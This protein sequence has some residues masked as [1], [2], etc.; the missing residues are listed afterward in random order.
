M[1]LFWDSSAILAIVFSEKRSFLATEAWDTA[2]FDY[3][4]RWLK[5]EASSALARRGATPAQWAYF[6]DLMNSFRFLDLSYK[7][8]NDVCTTNR[9][10]RLR[11][12]DAGH[13]FCFR[14]ASFVLPHLQFV[15]FDGEMVAIARKQG[16]RLWRP[17][18]ENASAST[19]VRES[20]SFYGRKRKRLADV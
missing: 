3:A 19:L 16:F 17:P 6:E 14:Q 2:E 8:I 4:W 1:D 7:D 9:N 5:V 15:C 11:A 10:W 13:L 20:R 18:E 12:A